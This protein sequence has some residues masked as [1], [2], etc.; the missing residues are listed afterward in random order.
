MEKINRLIFSFLLV[1]IVWT[2]GCATKKPDPLAGW[3]YMYLGQLDP[4]IVEDYEAFVQKLPQEDR[5][6]VDK[7]SFERYADGAGNHAV[8]FRIGKD[9]IFYGTWWDY[10]LIYNKENKRTKVIKYA[11]GKYGLW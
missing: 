4:A 5:I 6:Q 8:R 3:K 2:A 9:G 11:D 7:Y 10:V 1:A